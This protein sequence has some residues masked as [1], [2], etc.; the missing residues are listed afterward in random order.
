MSRSG[1]LRTQRINKSA[2]AHTWY[3]RNANAQR[4]TTVGQYG[5]EQGFGEG[6]VR[7]SLTFD[8]GDGAGQ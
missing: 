4:L 5:V 6:L 7:G 2:F 1:E 3:A 8:Q